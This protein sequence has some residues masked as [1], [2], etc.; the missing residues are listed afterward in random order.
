MPD[1]VASGDYARKQIYCPNRVVA[2]SHGSRF[3]RA[4]A[5]AACGR[6]GALLD[7]GC[8]D[9]TFIALT[10]GL[11]R[12]AVGADVDREQLND[13][14]A[15]FGTLAGVEFEEV[16]RLQAPAHAGAYDVVTCMEVLEHCTDQQRRQVLADLHRLC[17]KEGRIIISVPIEIGP[18]LAAKQFVRAIAAWRG[19]GDYQYRETYSLREL[20]RAVLARP[21]LARAE[22]SVETP[23]G[24]RRY[25][26]HKGFDWR[27]LEREL[28]ARFRV[29]R[30]LFTPLPVLGPVI[31]SQVWFVC[32]PGG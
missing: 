8:G 3:D 1:P 14:R 23:D 25:C 13:C 26:G 18:A 4:A 32:R 17:A 2:W 12:R 10:H 19:Q 7:Y 28:R 9:G 31:N 30:R 15:R 20:V 22:Y 27:T 5:L 11:F 16:P 6:G 24:L 21:G 29:D